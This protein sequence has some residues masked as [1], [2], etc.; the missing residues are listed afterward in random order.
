MPTFLVI[1]NGNVAQTIR[2]ANPPALNAAVR[3]AVADAAK[4]APKPTP[5][6]EAGNDQT[7]SGSYGMTQ[8]SGWKMSLN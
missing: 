4:S 3:N 1:K 8:G 7:V 6:T 2:G 5:A